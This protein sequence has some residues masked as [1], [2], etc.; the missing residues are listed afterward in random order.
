MT[1]IIVSKHWEINI[2]FPIWKIGKLPK[3][4]EVFSS[5]VLDI[6]NAEK[7]VGLD[8]IN[9]HWKLVTLS[10]LRW[11]KEIILSNGT[12]HINI[13]N[14]S[15]VG[16]LT[17]LIGKGC[18]NND[19]IKGYYPSYYS[20]DSW[21]YKWLI[22]LKWRWIWWVQL[23]E[24]LWIELKFNGGGI[25]IWDEKPEQD[26][27]SEVFDI[28]D[29][30]WNDK[31]VTL[32]DRWAECMSSFR[33]W[34]QIWDD[35]EIS[36]DIN[37]IWAIK[38]LK[39]LLSGE[40][41]QNSEF[42]NYRDDLT[43][44]KVI[45]KLTPT[46]TSLWLNIINLRW[47]GYKIEWPND[48]KLIEENSRKVLSKTLQ[49]NWISVFTPTKVPKKAKTVSISIWWADE[50]QVVFEHEQYI[51]FEQFVKKFW[52]NPVWWKVGRQ[53]RKKVVEE[54]NEIFVF[55]KIPLWINTI[56]NKIITSKW[57]STAASWE[58]ELKARKD[59]Y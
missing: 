48:R 11:K 53:D 13:G 4:G 26:T 37:N 52:K 55:E 21:R 1:D 20:T 51:M 58:Y 36:I 17:E 50:I 59:W 33:Y 28:V 42:T 38:F 8:C 44:S 29:K 35:T 30:D 15:P 7:L 22:Y 14:T 2:P 6:L 40:T 19:L 32:K 10:L 46:I 43:P 18:I 24:S 45:L 41:I 12:E 25:Y 3:V 57:D 39:R 9:I 16:F 31:V 27:I 23:L 34:I 5:E 47:I 49:N 56:Y 54:I